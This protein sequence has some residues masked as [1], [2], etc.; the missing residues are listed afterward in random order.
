LAFS[1]ILSAAVS[2]TF[3]CDLSNLHHFMVEYDI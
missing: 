1:L 2:A 3:Q